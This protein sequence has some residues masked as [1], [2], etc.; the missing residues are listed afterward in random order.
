LA[1]LLG[2]AFLFLVVWS[3]LGSVGGNSAQISSN[4]SVAANAQPVAQT[5][6]SSA[7][8][9]AA[10]ISPTGVTA[11]ATGYPFVRSGPGQEYPVLTSLQDGQKVSVIG[12]NADSS[13]LQIMLPSGQRGWSGANLLTVSSQLSGVPITQ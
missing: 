11:I 9:A 4:P 6:A 2:V 3:L 7:S 13:W 10:P 8:A 5:T 12:R 1:G